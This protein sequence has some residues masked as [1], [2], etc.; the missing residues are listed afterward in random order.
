[1][2]PSALNEFEAFDLQTVQSTNRGLARRLMAGTLRPP[3]QIQFAR[4][5]E[6]LKLER[7]GLKYPAIA[8]MIGMP[9]EKLRK[10]IGTTTYAIFQKY[11]GSR[12][13][14]DD[15]QAGHDRRRANRRR[16]ETN[17]AKALDYYDQ[18]YARHT[19]DDKNGRYKQGDYI[20]MDRA[21]R[22]SHLVAK[23]AGWTE[24]LPGHAK[25]KELKVGVIQGQMQ[26]IA[27]ADR[28]ETVVRITET[29][30]GTQIEVGSRETQ[31][32]GDEA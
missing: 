7:Q 27:A 12:Q 4:V 17:E 13:L 19:K 26:A 32:M 22:A 5:E 8:E 2:A 31:A 1:M 15:D 16:W 10:W 24:P 18:A 14:L 9:V 23:S 29:A 28:R 11:L 6:I 20:D 21:E 30:A 3:E 25:P